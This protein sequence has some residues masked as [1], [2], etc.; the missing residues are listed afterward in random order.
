MSAVPVRDRIL[1]KKQVCE[2]AGGVHGATLWRW[3]KTNGFPKPVQL[4][5][6]GTKVGWLESEIL[7]SLASRPRGG[8][9]LPK[10]WAGRAAQVQ[11]K[12]EAKANRASNGPTPKFGFRRGQPMVNSNPPRKAALLFLG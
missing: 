2:M 7:D 9:A 5:A 12:R 4:N 3:A 1:L 8:A 10:A 6:A 11:R